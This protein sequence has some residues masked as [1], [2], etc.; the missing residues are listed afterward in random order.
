MSTAHLQDAPSSA[1][2]T[3]SPYEESAPW[4]AWMTG[5]SITGIAL[6]L[7]A[8]VALLMIFRATYADKLLPGLS[9]NGVALGGLTYDEA[10]AAVEAQFTYDD[11]AVF[12]FRDPTNS[13]PDAPFWQM[14]AGE[15]G[16]QFDAKSAVDAA[17]GRGRSGSALD[18]LVTGALIWLNGEAIPA[19]ITYNQNIAL[20]R[21]LKIAAELERPGM[22][23]ALVV[24][25][26]QVMAVAGQ[27]GRVV[28]IPATLTALN[29]ALT[30][31]NT[32][33]EIP[34]VITQHTPNITGVELAEARARAALSAPLQLVADD[35][36]GGTLG[37][38]TI[39][40]EQ[41]ASLL[42][43]A[44]VDNGDSTQSYAVNVDLS[45][46]EAYLNTLAPGL[47]TQPID[48]RFHFNP[49]T[50]QL[51]VIKPSVGGRSLDV[52]RT[53]QALQDKI[54]STTDRTAQM[55]FN[56]D[57]ARYHNNVSALELGIT[58]MVVESTTTF[59]G[60]PAERRTN[61]A[62][63][64]ALYDGI[65]IGP[66]EEFSFNYWLGDL[67]EEAGFTE[68]NVI[69][70]GRTV[71]GIGG[72]ICQ[73][74][75]TIFR[76]AFFGGFTIIERNSH[77]Y[78]VGYYEQNGFPPGLDAAI[79][80]PER[81]FRF[82]NDTPYHLLIESSVYPGSDTLQIRFY[83]TN[84][85]RQ[86]EIEPPRVANVSP[87][88]PTL[89]E[90]NEELQPGQTLQVDYA[91]EGADVNVTRIIRDAA[92]Q[93]IKKDNIYTHYLSWGAIYQVAPG[94]TRLGQ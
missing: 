84:I 29:D 89:Y 60:S 75:T 15:L 32:G 92:G 25:G 52:A 76:A 93:E 17:F 13:A 5:L 45:A 78:R 70:G 16:V 94:D 38:W 43:V 11:T 39:S 4:L 10:L 1:P 28:D 50:R 41:I 51:E 21:L 18:D 72:G 23:G 82:Q 46:F 57:Q 87:A 26:T 91:A 48:G 81:D 67:S 40:Q 73:V 61:I 12:T 35:N 34:L 31:L 85:G 71:K 33:G 24:N 54:F 88:K 49:N 66:G 58:E 36:N 22:D 42:K 47:V 83:S 62:V 59:T 9:V 55:V 80:T 37:P 19:N 7:A 56:Y 14:S 63:G 53:L 44:L 3:R 8:L 30:R 68:G 6:A 27:A 65:I 20:A 74:S 77:G 90:A 69:F 86:V 64:A 79:W 2:R